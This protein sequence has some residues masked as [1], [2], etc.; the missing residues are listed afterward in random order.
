MQAADNFYTKPDRLYFKQAAQKL[1]QTAGVSVAGITECVNFSDE[2]L[3][4]LALY[5][6]SNEEFIDTP[7]YDPTDTPC[8]A[9]I[10]G[11][12]LFYPSG[13]RKLFPRDQHLVELEAEAYCAAPLKNSFAEVVGSIFIINSKPLAEA[14]KEK[15]FSILSLFAT[16][17]ALELESQQHGSVFNHLVE[18]LNIRKGPDFFSRFARYIQNLLKADCVLLSEITDSGTSLRALAACCQGKIKQNMAFD[19]AGAPGR[20]ALEKGASTCARAARRT[21]PDSEMLKRLKAESYVGLPLVDLHGGAIGLIEVVNTLPVKNIRAYESLLKVFAARAADEL[22]RVRDERE[23]SRYRDMINASTDL[24]AIIDRNY[25]HRYVNKNYLDF[26]HQSEARVINHDVAQLHGGEVF[27]GVVKPGLDKCLAGETVSYEIN[28]VR[29]DG[30]PRYLRTVHTPYYADKN[31]ICGVIAV[32]HDLTEYVETTGEL[33]RSR[34]Y[35]NKIIRLSPDLIWLASLDDDEIIDVNAGFCSATGWDRQELIGEATTR[36]GLYTLDF[37]NKIVALILK[38]GEINGREF[39]FRKKNGEPIYVVASSFFVELSGEKRILTIAKDITERKHT[40]ILLELESRCYQ[41]EAENDDFDEALTRIIAEIESRFSGFGF[42]ISL[43][44]GSGKRVLKTIAPGLPGEY[45]AAMAGAEAGKLS[46][47]FRM[48]TARREQVIVTD[49]ADDAFWRERADL[50]QKLDLKTCWSMPIKSGRQELIGTLAGYHK[51]TRQP[52]AFEHMMLHRI[53]AV[54]GAIIEQKMDDERLRE[55]RKK[56]RT[57]YHDAPSMF[58]SLDSAGRIMSVNEF[59]AKYLGYKADELIGRDLI[60]T[61]ILDEDRPMARAKLNE[62]FTSPDSLLRWEL[63]KKHRSGHAIW[64]R[65]TAHVIN[66]DNR[67]E[68]LVVC[69]DISENQR[70][71]QQL[72][73]QATHDALTRL[74]NRREFE[75]RLARL[76][77]SGASRGPGHAACY[78]DLDNFKLINDT[79]GHIAGDAMLKQ[80]SELL[81]ASVRGRDTLARLGGDEF[82]ILIENCTLTQAHG[83]AKKILSVVQDFRFAW[84]EN[85]FSVGVSIGL[86]P[87][88][89]TSGNVTDVLSAADSACYMA[90]ELGRN[91]IH[92]FS[93]DDDELEQRRDETQ[94]V[95][96]INQALEE[97]QLDLFYQEIVPLKP[98]AAG[99]GKRLEL[100]VRIK[101][102]DGGYILPG[103]FLPAAER[104]NLSDKIDQWVIQAALDWLCSDEKI[105]TRIE[106][107]AINISGHSL[108]NDN[109]L[110]FCIQKLEAS[111]LPPGKLC[112]EISETIA[113]ANLGNTRKFITALKGKGC[114]FALDDFGSGLSS[115]GYL[116]NLP[117]DYIKIDGAFIRDL[118]TDS[119]DREMVTTIRRVGQIVNKKTIAEFVENDETRQA[120]LEI[121]ID[122]AQGY[123]IAKPRPIKSFSAG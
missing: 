25:R 116:K 35:I 99:E 23:L 39:H 96:R 2:R 20:T 42:A 48:A 77:K 75:Q 65:E 29:G 70:L 61:L 10:D 45:C 63:R 40:E 37:R 56:F 31:Q 27:N 74:V 93:L 112:F 85:K 50:A 60:D 62:C 33:D 8:R 76:L 118:L 28:C 30:S 14:E 15:Y 47:R 87:I 122:Y 117:V 109:F 73:Y 52:A 3:R 4:I 34:E 46:R 59:G 108:D 106:T 19:L 21:W 92:V 24:I 36:I 53:A 95:F 84:D 104:H 22:N 120:L 91:R 67:Q 44:D 113:I 64:V 103:A 12:P 101:T 88:S 69:D 54:V 16:P 83:V 11:Q 58:F 5:R 79:C 38:E 86:V 43:L 123:A 90:K 111:R 97:N 105:L 49:I 68:I 98:P 1:C 51:Y 6:N 57:L 18:A 66:M 71:A 89:E 72:E 55:S 107:C 114:S 78:L 82:G 80:L 119:V 110:N 26:Y 121:G 13:V 102:A 100:L 17:I 9:V 81:A 7:E 32:S 94:W 115:F 41:I